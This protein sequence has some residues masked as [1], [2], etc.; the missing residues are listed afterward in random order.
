[1]DFIRLELASDSRSTDT[2]GVRLDNLVERLDNMTERR[3]VPG[4]VF[5]PSTLH[6]RDGL[7]A[8]LLAMLLVSAPGNPDALIT[9]SQNLAMNEQALPAGDRSMRR[10][11]SEIDRLLNLLEGGSPIVQRGVKLLKADADF[12]VLGARL[13][14]IL[15]SGR[16]AIETERK[17]RLRAKPIDNSAIRKLRDAGEVAMA[18]SP[19]EV[20]FFRGFSINKATERKE[21]ETYTVLF[22][23]LSKAQFV[24][25]PMESEAL[26]FE[27]I[28]AKGV[29]Q[30]AGQ[31]AWGL[32]T[33]RRR[34]LVEIS[35]H[36]DE[37]AFW[38]QVKLLARDVG[39]E[40]VL[41]VS[42]RAE[43]RILRE[44]IYGRREPVTPLKVERKAHEQ[45][46]DSYI[47]TI[48]S[49]DVYGAAFNPGKAWLFSPY[50]LQSLH[51][52]E[53]DEETWRFAP[54][55]L[56]SLPCIETNEDHHI[57]RVSF[58]TGEDLKGSLIAEFKQDAEWADWP[59]YEIDFEDI[60]ALRT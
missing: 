52:A 9:H 36:I 49:I 14:A 56:Q 26:G 6:G 37:L 32:F 2:Y 47:V 1:M 19:G 59:I 16:E 51:Y 44:L 3:V 33:R 12:S 34:E 38:E 8:P 39:A 48:E 31:R 25:P 43:G 18:K 23:G 50:I 42:S 55:L 54:Q 35:S 21:A 10:V 30:A 40:P 28:F 4:R 22:N 11:L 17:N 46:G 29:A 57:L 13:K 53:M 7:L 41:V 20:P 24:D 45:V 27:E 58:Q 60:D 5:T 15:S